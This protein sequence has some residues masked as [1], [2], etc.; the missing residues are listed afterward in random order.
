MY[1]VVQQLLICTLGLALLAYQL[2]LQGNVGE[3][4]NA[5]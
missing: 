4:I 2:L 5:C 1:H 3:Q